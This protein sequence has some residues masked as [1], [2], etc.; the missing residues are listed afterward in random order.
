MG[1]LYNGILPSNEKEK[2]IMIPTCNTEE[3][4]RNKDEQKPRHK[5]EYTPGPDFMHFWICHSALQE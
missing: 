4:H 2:E 5:R 3:S 1:C